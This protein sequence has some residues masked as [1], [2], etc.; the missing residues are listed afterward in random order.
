VI[1]VIASEAVIQSNENR[2]IFRVSFFLTITQTPEQDLLGKPPE[3]GHVHLGVTLDKAVLILTELMYARIN[4]SFS[5][6]W[7]PSPV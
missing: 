4:P 5:H 1:D 6:Y 3:R 7:L 2:I